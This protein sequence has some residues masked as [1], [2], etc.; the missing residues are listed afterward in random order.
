MLGSS[1]KNTRIWSITQL[2][3][4]SPF[5]PPV[6]PSLKLG[7]E[8][9]GADRQRSKR[10]PLDLAEGAEKKTPEIQRKWKKSGYFPHFSP[11]SHAPVHRQF[12]S[13]GSNSRE[14]PATGN[15]RN[16]NSEGSGHSSP[17]NETTAPKGQSQTLLLLCSASFC[18]PAAWSWRQHSH[19]DVWFLAGGMK[20]EL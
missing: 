9:Y 6:C 2:V 14:W 11:F 7:S 17:F 4:S 5:Y 3:V 15:Y 1:G 18:L 20:G 13:K 19:R 12:H 8:H 16:Q 10:N